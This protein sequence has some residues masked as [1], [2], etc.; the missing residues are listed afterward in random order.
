MLHLLLS[1]FP[2]PMLTWGLLLSL[3][4]HV[5]W[6]QKPGEGRPKPKIASVSGTVLDASSGEALPFASVVVT[7]ARDSSILGGVLSQEDGTFNLGEIE[8]GR[9]WLEIRFPGYVSQR[10][11]P[12]MCSPRN[13][14]SL[15]WKVGEVSMEPDITALEEA[16]VVLSLIHI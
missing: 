10:V 16:V 9:L 14:Q 11:G 15:Q 4:T 13:P 2:L 8:V 5:G 12:Q 6:A 1:R 7:S 3:S